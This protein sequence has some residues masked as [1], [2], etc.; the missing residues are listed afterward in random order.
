[1]RDLS[2]EIYCFAPSDC[3]R[4][5]EMKHLP[6]VSAAVTADMRDVHARLAKDGRFSYWV[7]FFAGPFIRL[8]PWMH[9]FWPRFF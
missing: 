8:Y 5:V 4:V 9:Q 1:M 6:Q 3:D 7:A 2:C